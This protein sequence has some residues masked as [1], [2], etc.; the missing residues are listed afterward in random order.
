MYVECVIYMMPVFIHC[1]ERQG[2]F[3][4]A[5]RDNGNSPIFPLTLNFYSSTYTKLQ[6]VRLLARLTADLPLP[7]V[8]NCQQL[9]TQKL[10]C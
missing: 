1:L 4:H 8:M 5:D 10:L 3:E 2:C 6:I 7:F 9:K